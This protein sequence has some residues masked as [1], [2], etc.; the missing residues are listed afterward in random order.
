MKN[1][2]VDRKHLKEYALWGSISAVCYM[3]P[4]LIFMSNHKYENL[5]LLYV[6]CALFMPPMFFYA[7]R[8]LNRP[9]DR[10][11]ATSMVI[12]GHLATI[13][14]VIISCILVTIAMLFF[15]PDLYHSQPS[16]AIIPNANAQN[17]VD[18]PGDL[19]F[20]IIATAVIGNFGVGSF[21]TLL[22]SYSGKR[23]QMKDSPSNLEAHTQNTPQHT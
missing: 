10:K 20:M 3:I 21:I 14:G 16:Q 4:V 22:T 12:A 6:G 13:A 5:Y 1:P 2:I 7:Y 11:R 19:L 17:L 18:Q 9:Y 23:D 15:F 8:L